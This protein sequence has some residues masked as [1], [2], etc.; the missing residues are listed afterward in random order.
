MD[1]VKF[2]EYKLFVEDTARFTYR[3]QMVSN[4]YVAVNSIILSAVAF[5]GKDANLAPVWQSFVILLVLSAGIVICLQWERLLYRYR[6]LGR[7]RFRLLREMEATAEMEGCAMMYHAEDAL[8][9]RD[10]QGQVLPGQ[11]LNISDRERWLP[12]VF[13]TVYVLFFLVLVIVLG[14]A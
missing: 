12:W 3:R 13:I 6:E 14:F 5:L 2:E 7:L 11:G 10:D 8:Y 4:I 1:T 9:P